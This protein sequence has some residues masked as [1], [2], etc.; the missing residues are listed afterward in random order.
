MRLWSLRGYK[1]SD[2]YKIWLLSI[3]C[4]GRCFHAGRV[5]F[6][7][8]SC[9]TIKKRES[10]SLGSTLWILLPMRPQILWECIG[11]ARTSSSTRQ[12]QTCTTSSWLQTRNFWTPLI[13]RHSR[14]D[15]ILSASTHRMRCRQSPWFWICWLGTQKVRVILNAAH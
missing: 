4:I 1:H 6:H 12:S 13:S 11:I 3:R 7:S 9:T 10:M 8:E 2:N 5:L 14:W 15:T